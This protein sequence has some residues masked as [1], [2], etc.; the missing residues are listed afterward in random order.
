MAV[1]PPHEIGDLPDLQVKPRVLQSV[2]SPP[3]RATLVDARPRRHHIDLDAAVA[4][5]SSARTSSSG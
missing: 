3:A 5:D 2:R 1:P 4:A